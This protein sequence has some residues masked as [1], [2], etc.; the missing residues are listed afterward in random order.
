MLLY[1]KAKEH[2]KL[3]LDSVL[4]GPF[5]YGTMVEPGN[6]TT[7]T[8]IRARVEHTLISQMKKRFMNQLISRQQ[9][10]FYKRESKLY[11]DF[12]TFTFMP[13]ETIHSYYM[14]FAQ[15]INDM[16]TIAYLDPEQLAFLADNGDTVISTQAFQELPTPSAFQTEDLDAFDSD[17]DDIPSAKAVL[18]ANLSSYD[19]YVLSEVPSHDTNIEN[20]MSY[21]S[22]QE[23]Q[24]SE[25]P[26]FVNDT[27]VDITSD[28]N[29]IS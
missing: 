17:C 5:Q 25:Q 15:L 16:H 1:I 27:E 2:D 10:L 29:I 28:S 26:S 8:T 14:R 11:D 18:M 23:T 22:V 13:E 19:S 12:D 6:E 7:P 9:T 4:N 21:Q 24:C 20:A 3:L